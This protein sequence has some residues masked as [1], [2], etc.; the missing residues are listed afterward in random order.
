MHF[1]QSSRERIDK[2]GWVSLIKGR[3][4]KGSG[5]AKVVLLC[6]RLYRRCVAGCLGSPRGRLAAQPCVAPE[7]K[8]LATWQPGV[9]PRLSG[10]A[11]RRGA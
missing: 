11:D 6:Q 8:Y 5:A 9:E 2:G 7:T 1:S 3:C 4:G 10:L